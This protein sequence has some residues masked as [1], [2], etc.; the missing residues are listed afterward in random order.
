MIEQ[1]DRIHQAGPCDIKVLA[2]CWF[3]LLLGYSKELLV[4][5]DSIQ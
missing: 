2:P 5:M 4:D 1:D 3:L